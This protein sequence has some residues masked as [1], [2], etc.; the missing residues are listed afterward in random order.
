VSPEALRTNA[1][2][3]PF[4]P[5]ASYLRPYR[6]GIAF[7]L[8]LLLVEQGITTAMPLLLRKIIDTARAALAG[9]APG[10]LWTGDIESEVTLYAAVVALLATVQWASAVAM[11]WHLSSM[12]RYVERDIRQRYA[13]HL[14]ALPLRY[15]QQRR[16]G[17]LM[18]RATNDVEA[19][20]RFL[21]HAFR[22]TLTGIL[23][24]VLSLIL[25]STIDWQLTL[26][27]LAPL[28]VMACTTRWVAGRV[29]SGFR[30]VQEH[31]AAMSARIQE[32]LAGVRVVKA[33]AREDQEVAEFAALNE[34]Y[35]RRNRRLVDVRSLFFPFTFLLSGVSIGI[36]LWLGGLRVI[37]G[38][39]TL[40]SFVAF[41]AYL[42]RLGRPMMLL[43]RMVDEFQRAR[44]SLARIESVLQEAPQPAGAAGEE[45]EVAGR[46]E[47]RHVSA[48]YDGRPALTDIDLCI[49]AGCTLAVVGRVGAGKS[50]LARL[51]PR[52]LEPAAG[53]VLIDGRP[54]QDLPLAALRRAIGYV[55][56]DSFL[57]SDTIA[58]NIALGCLPEDLPEGRDPDAPAAPAAA[59][60]WAAAVAQLGGDLA[61]FPAGMDTLVGERGVT[62]SGGQKQRTAL[63]RALVRRPRI[64]VLDDAL[65]SVDTR[66]EE[67]ILGQLRGIMATRTTVII[68]HRLS[69]VRD[70]DLIVVLDEG[71]IVERGTHAAL[72]ARQGAYA[73]MY[74]R[75]HLAEELG[76]L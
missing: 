37:D 4:R 32:S 60:E 53:E 51:I 69:T 3:N 7:G 25:M 22:M 62:L 35:V 43:G 30:Q 55:P 20:Q 56:Q 66:T 59:V 26:F 64:L 48:R 12:S 15:F 39:L 75:Q 42:I 36:I 61:T 65:A 27:A 24:F 29:R 17:D 70:A 72:L 76:E 13:A 31:F 18:A 8:V 33:Y 40:G 23:A 21:H 38:S 47:F 58:A 28:P 34:G 5:F 1:C 54:V 11:R 45:L 49:P 19:I 52:L 46:I 68:A 50:T 74:R 44:A 14:L 71:R 41:N 2:V 16:V 9:Q 10:R 73:D 6:R 57:F 67:A 63:A